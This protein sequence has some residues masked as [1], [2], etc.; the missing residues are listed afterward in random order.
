M[1]K[2]KKKTRTGA[3][4]GRGHTF[5]SVWAAID[6]LAEAQERVARAVAEAQEKAE[7]ERLKTEGFTR[8]D[9]RKAEETTREERRRAEADQREA[10]ER[11]RKDDRSMDKLMKRLEAQRRYFE[12]DA[13]DP[14][15]RLW[16]VVQNLALGDFKRLLKSRGIDVESAGSWVEV[17]NKESGRGRRLL[18]EYSLVAIEGGL[19]VVA[20]VKAVL[21]DE[22]VR[23]FL[24]KLGRFRGHFPRRHIK[25]SGD[26]GDTLEKLA[27][28][29]EH[30]NKRVL[31]AVAFMEVADEGSPVAE[32][33]PPESGEADYLAEDNG[34]FVIHCVDRGEDI[35]EDLENSDDFEPRE[36]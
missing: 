36:F 22:D 13:V 31:G 7:A 34:L 5:E 23:N 12:R 8:E 32:G 6:R 20:E 17:F 9:R 19:A 30:R 28:F 35:T 11:R 16:E 14:N 24:K 25:I 29:R 33:S 21:R 3:D 15:T 18:D 1:G 27:R 10:D 26:F 4:A 2:A